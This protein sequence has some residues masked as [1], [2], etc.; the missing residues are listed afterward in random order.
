MNTMKLGIAV[1]V[2]FATVAP[3]LADTIRCESDNGRERY[4]RGN[5]RGGVYLQTQLSSSGCYQGD[6]WGYDGGGIWVSAGC[7]A[8]FQTGGNYYP[9]GYNPNG[10]Y[11][12]NN[13]NH[14]NNNNDGAVAAVALAAIIGAAVVA[15]SSSKNKS[16]SGDSYETTY[17]NGCNAGTKDRNAGKSRDYTRHSGSYSGSNEQAYSSG[18]NKCWSN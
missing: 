17:N 9:N 16:N 7:R 2:A 12:N 10:Y 13:N 14:H 1:L 4:C 8:I 5:T 11:P 18:Y 3:A 15:S 6:T